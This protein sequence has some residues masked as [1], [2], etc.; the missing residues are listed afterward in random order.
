VLVINKICYLANTPSS[1]SSN[2][3]SS[4]NAS[5]HTYFPSSNSMNN[6]VENATSNTNMQAL[7]LDK[8]EMKTIDT[9][10]KSNIESL[11]ATENFI[12]DNKASGS[13][14][15]VLET[16]NNLTGEPS[17]IIL[18]PKETSNPFKRFR[19]AS[20]SPVHVNNQENQLIKQADLHKHANT[21]TSGTNILAKNSLSI[22]TVN[23]SKASIATDPLNKSEVKTQSA[24]VN[25]SF[26]WPN[27]M[28]KKCLLAA[29]VHFFKHVPLFS[30]W[31]KITINVRVEVPNKYL[32]PIEII[33]RDS[34]IPN[35]QNAFWFA[36]IVEL[37][38]IQSIFNYINP[39]LI[40][41]SKPF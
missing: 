24:T 4:N 9:I 11:R 21:E 30:L 19:K 16:K 25:G 8:T 31:E 35:Y 13:Q 22:N 7:H 39:I 2:T 40:K 23:C 33:A 28:R 36:T 26:S 3:I 12:N 37:G 34:K 14:G 17:S 38:Y 18:S 10:T 41:L 15:T 32:P 1:I 5:S 27:F 20:T 6:I 29:P